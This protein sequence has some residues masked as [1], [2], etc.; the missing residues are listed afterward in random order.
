M[1]TLPVSIVPLPVLAAP[2]AVV[3]VPLP[4]GMF[5]KT[6]SPAS[7]EDTLWSTLICTWL[8]WLLPW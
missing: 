7:P 2:A 3:N 1:T 5:M 4:A 8:T 6:E